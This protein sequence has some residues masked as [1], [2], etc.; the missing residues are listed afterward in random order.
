MTRAG[1]NGRQPAREGSE[2][3]TTAVRHWA[4]SDGRCP[5][6]QLPGGWQAAKVGK[7][8]E[9]LGWAPELEVMSH[10]LMGRGPREVAAWPV[11]RSAGGDSSSG[12]GNSGTIGFFKLAPENII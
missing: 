12:M 2:G 1:S 5:R 10:G 7:R 6:S 3:E 11:D 8:L 4:A 9:L